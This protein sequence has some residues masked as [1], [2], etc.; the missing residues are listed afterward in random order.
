MNLTHAAW[1]GLL[2]LAFAAGATSALDVAAQQPAPAPP[3]G[4]P[5]QPAAVVQLPTYRP[6]ALALVQPAAGGSVP[7]DRPVIVF[8]FAPGEPNDPIDASTFAVTVDGKNRSSLF[9]V[10]SAEA[11]GPIAPS[12]DKSEPAPSAGAHRVT[13]R[14]CSIRGAC[15][16][17]A[18]TVVAV[19]SSAVAPEAR[20]AD[21]RRSILDAL[22]T[23]AR[24][25]LEP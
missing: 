10:S 3:S 11:W 12:H 21:R 2:G 7:Q 8:R 16:E 5:S 6:P 18:T 19:P 9:Q 1:R 24:K 13:A 20:V 23:A 4:Q 14:I 17:T 22:L 15:S 25:L